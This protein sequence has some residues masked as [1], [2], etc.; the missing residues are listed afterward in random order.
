MARTHGNLL[1]PAERL[2]RARRIG[3]TVGRV[4]LG[5]KA[6]QLLARRLRPSDMRARWRRFHRSSAET[7]YDTAVEL[8]GL[9]LKGCQYL[10]ARPDLLPPEWVDVL[11]RLQDRVPPRPFPVVRRSVERELGRPLEA[12]FDSFAPTPVASAS[13]AQVHAAVLRDGRRV[14]VKVQYPEI[15]SLVRSDLANLRTLFSA[16]GW[17]ERDFDPMLLLEEL[18]RYVPRELDFLAEADNA[19]RVAA[20]FAE[21]P[22]VR[23]PD[24]H[25]E[26]TTRRVLVMEYVEGLKITDRKG[27]ARAGIEPEAVARLLADVYGEQILRHGFF[28]ADPHPGNLMIDPEGPRLVLLDFGLADE[29]PEG[30]AEAVG[31][32]LTGVLAADAAAV[33]AAL[34]RLGFE[35]RAGGRQALAELAELG[36][37]VLREGG[38]GRRPPPETLRRVGRE[39]AERIRANPVVRVPGHVVLLA[40]ALGLLAGVARALGVRLDPLAVVLPHARA[41]AGRPSS[42]AS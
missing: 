30:F 42:P 11:S 8:Q 21:R 6:N 28:H 38:A 26:L 23:V 16:I 14:A 7:V 41:A 34:E 40:R 20:R 35:T 25:R 32:L 4:Y 3:V 27:L 37:A 36:L 10:G 15:E 9:I 29:L 2:E 24:V 13:L 19:E 12:V 5:I 31:A 22:D 17:L 1:S 39:L 18:A 33:G